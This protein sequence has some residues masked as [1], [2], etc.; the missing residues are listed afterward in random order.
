MPVALAATRE[1]SM[2]RPLMNGPRSVIRTLS[3]YHWPCSSRRRGCRS[4]GA[5]RGRQG[6]GVEPFAR[7]RPAPVVAVPH[8]VLARN[9]GF[10]LCHSDVD[11]ADRGEKIA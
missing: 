8:A 6:V 7:R 9:A 10:R 1:R 11:R 3:I 2:Q 5:V 4:A